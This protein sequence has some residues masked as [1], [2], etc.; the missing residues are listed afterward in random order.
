DGVIIERA[1]TV[2]EL[3]PREQQVFSV[4]GLI[5]RFVDSSYAYRFG[6]PPHLVVAARLRAD[7]E[8]LLAQAFHLPLGLEKNAYD[9]GLAASLTPMTDG[10][11]LLIASSER[12]AEF[13]VVEAPGYLPSDNYFHLAPKIPWRVVLEPHGAKQSPRGKLRALNSTR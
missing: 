12:F 6:P 11:Y 7:D 5:G 2:I 10:R 8:Q 4:D 9:V 1:K 13:V 3:Q